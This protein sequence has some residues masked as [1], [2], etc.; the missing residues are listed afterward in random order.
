[1]WHELNT[2]LVTEIVGRSGLHFEERVGG[3]T[4]IILGMIDHAAGGLKVAKAR[5]L[6]A[7]NNLG[8]SH[9]VE[10]SSTL[11]D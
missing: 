2:N 7:G 3:S 10:V 5:C 1:M 6:K 4:D 8:L 9:P 11:V